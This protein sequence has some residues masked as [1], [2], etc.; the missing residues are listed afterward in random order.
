MRRTRACRTVCTRLRP[1]ASVQHT[2]RQPNGEDRPSPS[3]LVTSMP[4]HGLDQ[5]LADRQAKAGAAEAARRRLV[6]L[7][8][9]FEHRADLVFRMPM[10][11]SRTAM[12]IAPS[13]A[14]TS[15]STPPVSVN[16]IAL[17]TQIGSSP[18]RRRTGSLSTS[19]RHVTGRRSPASS[20]P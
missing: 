9:R 5:P 12:R 2:H 7:R 19:L 14:A 4:A 10:P 18:G 1:R 3:L 8:E 17:L 20:S 16:L 11:V 6:G 15:T 13:S